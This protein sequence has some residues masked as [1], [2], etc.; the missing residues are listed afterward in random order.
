M[1]DSMQD[2]E[3]CLKGME[4]YVKSRGVGVSQGAFVVKRWLEHIKCTT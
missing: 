2:I 3:A 4:H 1:F